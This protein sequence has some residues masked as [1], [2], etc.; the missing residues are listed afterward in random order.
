MPA[1]GAR[2][3]SREPD[4]NRAEEWTSGDRIRKRRGRMGI[5]TKGKSLV[6]KHSPCSSSP[7]IRGRAL[8]TT[9]SEREDRGRRKGALRGCLGRVKRSRA[10]QLCETTVVLEYLVGSRE[11]VARSP[12]PYYVTPNQRMDV[13]MVGRQAPRKIRRGLGGLGVNA[14]AAA[15]RTELGPGGES[16]APRRPP[17]P[18]FRGRVRE[19]R[20]PMSSPGPLFLRCRQRRSLTVAC[21]AQTRVS[22]VS[23]VWGETAVP[24]WR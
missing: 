23:S 22:G 8:T 7:M 20:L 11:S 21:A 14:G 3:R 16:T 18:F 19:V 17:P 6:S 4:E 1:T 12:R 10:Q 13:V 15:C 9:H 24:H 2:G 5:S